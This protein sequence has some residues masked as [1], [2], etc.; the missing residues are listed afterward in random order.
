MTYRFLFFIFLLISFSCQ[1]GPD[2]ESISTAD[3]I[4]KCY[5]PLL[6]INEEVQNLLKNGKGNEAEKLIPQMASRHAASKECTLALT[7]NARE[8]AGLDQ[9]K[10]EEALDES[11]PKV[12]ASVK[13]LLFE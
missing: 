6:E 8:D 1:S 11:C 9:T 10:M 5:Q 13:E 2:K 12:W 3:G 7:K 4:C